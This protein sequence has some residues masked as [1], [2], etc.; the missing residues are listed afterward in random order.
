MVLLRNSDFSPCFVFQY[1]KAPIRYL[2][3]SR[4]PQ[5]KENPFITK[6]S[7]EKAGS[8]QK[9]SSFY[10]FLYSCITSFKTAAE[11][12]II[13]QT[14]GLESQ[15]GDYAS[16]LC[17]GA[18]LVLHSS[19]RNTLSLVKSPSAKSARVYSARTTQIEIKHTRRLCGLL[20]K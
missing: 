3:T 2:Q 5:L 11:M 12:D 15:N 7:E 19:C 8:F 18:E 10:Y 6:V 9:L 20:S 13:P 16:S 1:P 4:F 17:Q 14:G